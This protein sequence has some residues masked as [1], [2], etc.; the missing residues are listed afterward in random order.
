MRTDVHDT[1]RFGV[2]GSGCHPN[3]ESLPLKTSCACLADGRNT[4]HVG[5]AQISYRNDA[6]SI[7][8]DPV[9]GGGWSEPTP[10]L[11]TGGRGGRDRSRL[12]SWVVHKVNL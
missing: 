6:D 3:R 1:S 10:Y 9:T 11:S 8:R 2:C 4:F 7:G 5:K 12:I